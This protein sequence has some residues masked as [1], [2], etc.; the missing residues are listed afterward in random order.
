M[1]S[2][3]MW[4]FP[5]PL[6]AASSGATAQR[7]DRAPARWALRGGRRRPCHRYEACGKSSAPTPN[8]SESHPP[9][10]W[11]RRGRLCCSVSGRAPYLRNAAVGGW[12]HLAAGRAPRG[13]FAERQRPAGVASGTAAV[14]AAIAAGRRRGR[15]LER[16]EPRGGCGARHGRALVPWRGAQRGR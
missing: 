9:R 3:R 14:S 4:T 16:R 10:E 11:R 15:P 1:G 5:H 12:G 8:G 7:R 13:I 6:Q 2:C